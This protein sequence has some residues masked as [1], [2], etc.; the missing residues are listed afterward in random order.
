MNMTRCLSKIVPLAEKKAM[1]SVDL[2]FVQSYNFRVTKRGNFSWKS[3]AQQSYILDQT[4]QV[5]G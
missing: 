3:G 5:T 2:K 1:T 4:V